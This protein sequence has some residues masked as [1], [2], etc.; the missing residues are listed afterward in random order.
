MKLVHTECTRRTTLFVPFRRRW[1]AASRSMY[2]PAMVVVQVKELF[3]SLHGPSSTVHFLPPST[4]S[5][6]AI[7]HAS[8]DCAPVMRDSH[9]NVQ[10]EPVQF[11]NCS[12]SFNRFAPSAGLCRRR[13]S[14]NK[15]PH[16]RSLPQISATMRP[17]TRATRSARALTE[18]QEPSVRPSA[19]DVSRAHSRPTSNRS[20]RTSTPYS[21]RDKKPRHRMTDKQLERLEE[22]YQQDTHPSRELKQALGEQVGM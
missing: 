4:S 17:P 1:P 13:F 10:S 18:N 8:R 3:S 19:G 11:G 5:A 2:W 20:S 16:P 9:I 6:A 7:C 21:D 12:G 22:L 14:K 15:A